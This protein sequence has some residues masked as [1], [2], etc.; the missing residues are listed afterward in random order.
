MKFLLLLVI[1]IALVVGPMAM[2]RPNPEQRRREQLRLAA[3][4][5]GLRFAMRHLPRLKTDLEDSPAI[6]CYYLPPPES[7]IPESNWILMR[8]SY[9]HE[10]NFYQEWDWIGD[11]RPASAVADWLKE[12]M[13]TVPVSFKAIASGMAGTSVY[14]TE[15]GVAKTPEEQAASLQYLHQLLVGVQANEKAALSSPKQASRPG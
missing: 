12:Q 7:C 2:L 15:K 10:G 5:L 8:T 9:A 3:R 13:T 6:P 1:A 11:G 4:D 14:W